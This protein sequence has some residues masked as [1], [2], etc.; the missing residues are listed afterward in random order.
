MKKNLEIMIDGKSE[1][2]LEVDEIGK[3]EI[4]VVKCELPKEIRERL[5]M[6]IL[7]EG[8]IYLDTY[9]NYLERVQNGIK[10]YLDKEVE[11]RE[12]IQN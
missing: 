4:K 2:I 5:K 12:Y 9:S 6:N 8:T 1:G 7:A 11:I 3:D 10:H